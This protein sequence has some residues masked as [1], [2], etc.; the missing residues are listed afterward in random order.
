MKKVT[1]LSLIFPIILLL[2]LSSCMSTGPKG[3]TGATGATG[4]KG[5]T[6]ATGATGAA[7]DVP[8]KPTPREKVVIPSDSSSPEEIMQNT[9]P[10]EDR[11]VFF[12]VAMR[13]RDREEEKK[14]ALENAAAQAVMYQKIWGKAEFLKQKTNTGI[15]Y[16]QSVQIEYD[17]SFIPSFVERLAVVTEYQDNRG[18][19]VMAEFDEAL[20]VPLN[21]TIKKAKAA[22]EWVNIPPSIPGYIVGVGVAQAKRTLADSIQSADEKAFEEIIKQ[23]AIEIKL[24]DESQS[25][26]RVGTNVESTSMETAE[27]GING[28]YVISRTQS[29]DGKYYYSLAVCPEQDFSD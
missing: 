15:G 9:M 28:F 18:T 14:L 20:L 22:P 13:M 1:F 4:V 7:A 21:F 6:G 19:Y 8:L 27:G 17:K 24:L 3:S 11:P 12:G 29:T 16:L 23:I 2:T 5:A 10:Y 25:I 26:D